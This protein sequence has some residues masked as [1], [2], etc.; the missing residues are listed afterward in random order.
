MKDKKL[1]ETR[2]IKPKIRKLKSSKVLT[3]KIL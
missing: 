3:A 2:L 1:N